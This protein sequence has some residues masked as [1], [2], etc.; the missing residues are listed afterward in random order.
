MSCPHS[1][2]SAAAFSAR[3]LSSACRWG[4]R[5]SLASFLS[6]PTPTPAPAPAPDTPSCTNWRQEVGEETRRDEGERVRPSRVRPSRLGP[7][8]LPWAAGV[9]YR[10]T[11]ATAPLRLCLSP[12]KRPACHQPRQEGRVRAQEQMRIRYSSVFCLCL[13]LSLSFS[14]LFFGVGMSVSLAQTK[15]IQK[16]VHLH[17][18]PWAYFSFPSVS[19]L[20]SL[21]EL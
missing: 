16:F 3:P 10:V 8:Q 15:Q 21:S 6:A 4:V 14:H 13:S 9:N 7:R 20:F 5:G 11:Q 2:H 18:R 1:T 17:R 19:S 12:L